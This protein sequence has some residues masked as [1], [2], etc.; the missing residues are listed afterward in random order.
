MAQGFAKAKMAAASS[1]IS[2]I[3]GLQAAL[4]AKSATGHAHVTADVTGLDSSLAAKQITSEKDA[5]SG[6]AGLNASS[7]ITKGVD[8]TDDLIVD[9]SSKGLILKDSSG[10]Y[11][12]LSLSVLGV[13]ATTDLG[14]T[15][16]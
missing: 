11:W 13:L 12:R 15:K 1:G 7:R 16:P 8:S 14:T 2:A 4:D 9:S 6:Y 3:T 10:H 5:A